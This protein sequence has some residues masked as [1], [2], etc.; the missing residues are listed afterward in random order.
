MPPREKG[1]CWKKQKNVIYEINWFFFV[2]QSDLSL[3]FI[4]HY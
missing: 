4:S 2:D 1:N 3:D